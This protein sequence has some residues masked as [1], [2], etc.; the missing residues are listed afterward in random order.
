MIKIKKIVHPHSYEI[1]QARTDQA[2]L[3]GQPII[4]HP[5]WYEN[6]E[7]G[8]LYYD[9]YGCVAWPTAV[10][11]KG[12]AM[13][14]YVGI[15]GVVKSKIE[16]ALIQDAA[17]Q[18]LAE[19]AARDVPTLLEMILAMRKDYGFGLHP[20]LLQCWYG[21]PE[22]FVKNVALK[23]ERLVATGGEKAV[24]LIIPPNDFY[25]PKSFDNYVH[26]LRS[27]LVPNNKRFFF[28]GG[29]LLKQHLRAFERDN[30]AVLAIG[31]L[32]H[33]LLGHCT[34]AGS[35]RKTVFVIEDF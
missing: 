29:N 11:E 26:S 18:L 33:T 23:N 24:I 28:G 1:M 31:G 22:R 2:H 14:G 10:S 20:D 25:D 13:P 30:P 17:F 7:T 4:E 19:G 34:W 6:T 3:T 32:V 12:K 21:D 9:L 15:L 8:Q 16:G 27:V 5:F 35:S